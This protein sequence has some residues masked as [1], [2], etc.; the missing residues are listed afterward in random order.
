MVEYDLLRTFLAES[1]DSSQKP[2]GLHYT[3]VSGVGTF[4][5]EQC[6]GALPGRLLRSTE[7]AV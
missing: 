7:V 6:S 5:D 2:T 1:L 3:L 4:G